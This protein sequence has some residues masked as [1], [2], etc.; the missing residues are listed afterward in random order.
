MGTAANAGRPDLEAAALAEWAAA[1]GA[2]RD[3]D[4][5][6]AA[7]ARLRQLGLGPVGAGPL[8][9]VL[10]T[11]VSALAGDDDAV[12]AAS[13]PEPG[14][15]GSE[16]SALA[17]H[18]R[19][20]AAARRGHDLAATAMGAGLVDRGAP[21]A[22][23]APA[24]VAWWTA[25]PALAAQLVPGTVTDGAPTKADQLLLGTHAAVVLAGTGDLV[26]ATE[27]LAAARSAAAG[28]PVTT[29]GPELA[30]A[31]AAVEVADGTD[32]LAEAT[33]SRM[34]RAVGDD[35]VDRRWATE[36][37]LV[38][39]LARAGV[40]RDDDPSTAPA[41]Q[42]ASVLLG[43]RGQWPA[44]PPERWPGANELASALPLRWS[45]ELASRA[46]AAQL[47]EGQ[48]LADVVLAGFGPRARA[49]LRSMAGPAA[50]TRTA[51]STDGD[52]V[53]AGARALLGDVASATTRHLEIE[54]LGPTRLTRE[55]ERLDHPA[56]DRP[57]VRTL[58]GYLAMGGTTTR[59]AAAGA[60]W[61]DR[62]ASDAG[63]NLRQHLS[64]LVEA[65]EPGRV[66]GEATFVVCS[67]GDELRLVGEPHLVVD[68]ARFDHAVAAIGG[69]APDA[70][71]LRQMDAALHLW[72]GE[73]LVDLAPLAW[74]EEARDRLRR[75]FVRLGLAAGRAHLALGAPAVAVSRAVDVLAVDP[76]SELAYQLLVAGH[77]E[78]G[79][80]AAARRALQR[81]RDMLAELGVDETT[82]TT[83]LAR[84]LDSG[85]R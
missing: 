5:L 41:P 4:A 2:R 8:A 3:V 20:A 58:L 80:R 55:G 18:L 13:L 49:M 37:V 46:R 12:L 19:L 7:A 22:R 75:S 23:W 25:Q 11:W 52:A 39:V 79:D 38:T 63:R 53:R 43:L 71:D 77:L 59:R 35:A 76:W 78:A 68:V 34:R 65:L 45:L 27:A 51:G 85:G 36:P 47:P 83:M 26:G 48:A 54:L 1:S 33:L 57:M 67:D 61:P 21:L 17:Q 73:P 81:A 50:V 66:S 84:R 30:L 24:L 70:S 69:A 42:A 82:A 64:L 6:H 16:W 62:D 31:E 56:L 15:V 44:V 74:V 28:T 9:G 10:E 29:T 14:V 40:T 60:L 72:R 32:A